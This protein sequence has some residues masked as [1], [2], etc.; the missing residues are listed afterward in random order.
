[1]HHYRTSWLRVDLLCGAATQRVLT[2]AV[3][4]YVTTVIQTGVADGWHFE[5]IRWGKV[6]RLHFRGNQGFVRELLRDNAREHF[7]N[8]FDHDPVFDRLSDYG[9]L[10]CIV[11]ERPETTLSDYLTHRF[12]Y[13]L[14]DLLLGEHAPDRTPT[15]GDLL[16]AAFQIHL[17][18]VRAL[19]WS[20]ADAAAH[21]RTLLR[22]TQRERGHYHNRTFRQTFE[23]EVQEVRSFVSAYWDTLATAN[24]RPALHDWATL[25][26]AMQRARQNDPLLSR[27]PLL[28]F[29][30]PQ[31]R[32]INNGLGIFGKNEQYLFF[33]LAESLS[34]VPTP[35][36]PKPSLNLA[37]RLLRWV[38]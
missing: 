20:R 18:T 21:F 12:Q 1:M 14:S 16:T 9:V 33:Q 29:W 24:E 17:T 34:D 23:R 25:V 35:V 22:D 31:L 2:Q 37:E 5:R 8:Y 6:L 32:R 30:S 15:V 10:E 13:G 4:P 38:S 19:G 26:G 7:T 36:L 3:R 27:Q 28:D 11:E